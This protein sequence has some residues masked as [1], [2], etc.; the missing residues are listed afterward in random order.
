MSS[1]STSG[2]NGI[3]GIIALVAVVGLLNAWLCG[4]Y[5]GLIALGGAIIVGLWAVQAINGG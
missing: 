1:G 2:F 3:A 4:D 5:I